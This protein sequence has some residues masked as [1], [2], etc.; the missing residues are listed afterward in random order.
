MKR[1]SVALAIMVAGLG[2]A[3]AGCGMMDGHGSLAAGRRYESSGN[4]RAAY[5]EAKKVLQK[6]NKNGDAWLL[7]AQASLWLGDPHGVLNDIENAKA[8]GVPA[9]GWA[10]P[11]GRAL[12]VT[13]QYDELLKAVS[14]DQVSASADRARV[15]VLRGDAYLGLKQMEQA[16]KA[17]QAAL[18]LDAKDPSALVGL[19]RVASAREDADSAVAYVQKALALAP[20]DAGAWTVKGDLAFLV[21]N[22][23]GAEEAYEKALASKSKDLLPQQRFY[24][25][26]RLADT[27][28]R[29][30]QFAQALV[31]L[32]TLQKMSPQQP[33]PHYLRAVIDYKQQHFDSATSELQQVLKVLPNNEPAQLLLGAVNYAQG[34][35]SQS[36]MY[37]SNVIGMDSQN[38]AAR[39]LL[40]LTLYREGRT[41]QAV[42]TLQAVMPDKLSRA[43]LLAVLEHQARA[44][45]GGNAA[46]TAASQALAAQFAG[47]GQA[48]AAGNETEA[49]RLLKA[50]PAGSTS[51]ESRRYSMM[52]LAYVRE[53]RLADA[54]QVASE[55][56]KQ[57][58]KVS[59]AHM[60][61]ATALIA[62]G[63]RSRARTEYLEA[64]RLDPNNM[65]AL[66]N[67]GSLDVLEGQ[68]AQAASVYGQILKKDPSNVLAMTHLGQIAAARGEKGDAV[69]WFKRAIGAAPKLA[70]PYLGL[71]AQYGG[72]GQF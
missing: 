27:Q 53:N 28:I 32:Q 42:D 10:V 29:Q 18:A 70:A 66:L 36:E 8:N 54:V 59:D 48:I 11:M 63:D 30:D 33:Y 24:T 43:Q 35:F 40:A 17:Y 1:R 52:V 34:N 61:Y 5:I 2:F 67:L 20:E 45:L 68:P 38:A 46:P 62:A 58:P 64:S 12:L 60:I 71:I 31:N 51:T 49:L 23:A 19:A 39:R 16:N 56:V 25:Q 15:Q 41:D 6:D 9:S 55:Y 7:L 72:N 21:Q 69:K 47:A 13:G 44:G 57:A 50:L 3:L 65:V 37:L 22:Y 14:T 26:T 4:Y